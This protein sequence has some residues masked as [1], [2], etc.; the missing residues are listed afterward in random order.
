MVHLAESE[1]LLG[2]VLSGAEAEEGAPPCFGSRC[3]KTVSPCAH[4]PTC[5]ARCCSA[6]HAVVVVVVLVVVVVAV[7][8]MVVVAVV[9]AIAVAVVQAAAEQQ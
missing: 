2:S 4:K 9:A 1:W 8:V 3:C 6:R 5:I 7:V